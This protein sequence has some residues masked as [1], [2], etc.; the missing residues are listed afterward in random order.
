MTK[1]SR[2]ECRRELDAQICTLKKKYE[3]SARAETIHTVVRGYADKRSMIESQPFSCLRVE[4]GQ[5]RG[6][7]YFLV[8]HNRSFKKWAKWVTDLTHP[9]GHLQH[10]SVAPTAEDT[11]CYQQR[12]GDSML[13]GS[14]KRRR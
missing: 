1:K 7:E 13:R 4:Y 6:G 8:N 12:R 14:K 10:F 5:R 2:F 9:N 11:Y 3:R